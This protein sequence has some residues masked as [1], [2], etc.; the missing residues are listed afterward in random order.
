MILPVVE[1]RSEAS[2]LNKHK[3]LR[4]VDVYF[5]R[6]IAKVCKSQQSEVRKMKS[7][8]SHFDF[9]GLN[10]NAAHFGA[11]PFSIGQASVTF[12]SIRVI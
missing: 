9:M 7:P 2:V 11:H 5:V 8:A 12:L 4:D 3:E 10:D 6:D 1:G